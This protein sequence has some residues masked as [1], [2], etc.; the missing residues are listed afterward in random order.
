LDASEIAVKAIFGPVAIPISQIQR[1]QVSGTAAAMP[2]GLVLR[3]PFDTD[4]GGRVTDRSGGGNNGKIAGA[5]WTSE[6]KVGGAMS[7]NGDRQAVVV[8]NPARLQLQNL[9]IM[10][11]V[12]RGR[13]DKVYQTDTDSMNAHFF[14]YGMNGYMFGIQPSGQLYFGKVGGELLES[15]Y[16]IHDESF[17]HVAVSKQGSRVVFYL[18]GVAAPESDFESTFDFETDV[19]VGARPDDMANSFIGVIDEVSVFNRGLSGDEVKAIFDSQK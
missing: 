17:H 5:P 12:K 8:G 16:L 4:E 1:I 7:F 11:W 10:A 3:Y 13:L 15:P 19:A 9:T 18:D 6:G 2:D 14:S